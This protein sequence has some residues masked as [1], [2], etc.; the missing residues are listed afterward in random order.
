[1]T[2]GAYRVTKGTGMIA[3][4]SLANRDAKRLLL[5]VLNQHRSPGQRLKRNPMQTDRETERA[6]RCDS[7]KAPEHAHETS[8]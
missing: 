1:M 3:I 6:D 5:R 7:P 4:E 2:A 8:K